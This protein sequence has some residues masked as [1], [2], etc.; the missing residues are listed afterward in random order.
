MNKLALVQIGNDLGTTKYFELISKEIQCDWYYYP[1]D[2][3]QNDFINELKDLRKNY[4]KILLGKPI[5]THL[6]NYGIGEEDFTAQAVVN[7]LEERL[8][9]FEGKHIVVLGRSKLLGRPIFNKLLTKNATV[10]LCHSHSGDLYRYI[11]NADALVCAT[12]QKNLID[13]SKLD[14]KLII[15]DVG[16]PGDC[17]NLEGKDVFKG[18]GK[19][20]RELLY[21]FLK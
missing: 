3:K 8:N 19:K 21:S 15:V 13:C 18:I 20:T 9:N 2:I 7:Y 5:P 6:N 17:Y 1:D 16:F 4:K 11:K 14:D 12:G 10:T